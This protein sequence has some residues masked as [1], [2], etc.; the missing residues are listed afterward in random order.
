MPKYKSTVA[1]YYTVTVEAD[2]PTDAYFKM[3]SV[4]TND[5]LHSIGFNEVDLDYSDD[6]PMEVR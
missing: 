1:V 2:S 6:L 3:E 5:Y 4:I